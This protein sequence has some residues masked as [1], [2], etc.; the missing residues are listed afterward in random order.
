[1][2]TGNKSTYPWHT[3]YEALPK[4]S[5]AVTNLCITISHFVLSFQN[6]TIVCLKRKTYI[7]IINNFS[8]EL[9][10][11]SNHQPT[12]KLF[13]QKVHFGW[14]NTVYGIL[15]ETPAWHWCKCINFHLFLIPDYHFCGN[16]YLFRVWE[17]VDTG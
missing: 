2:F 16:I 17:Q 10:K 4:I 7:W 13:R 3:I 12:S 6:L 1:M 15:F 9:N 14:L 11:V 8:E 5:T